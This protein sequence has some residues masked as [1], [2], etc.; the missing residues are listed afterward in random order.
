MAESEETPYNSPYDL[1][2]ALVLAPAMLMLFLM[3]TRRPLRGF[4]ARAD[5]T[6][7]MA[8]RLQDLGLLQDMKHLDM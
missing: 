2:D 8:L 7:E 3:P 5:N 1:E 4:S 6:I